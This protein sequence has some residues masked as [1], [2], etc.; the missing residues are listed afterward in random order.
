MGVYLIVVLESAGGLADA[1]MLLVE[2]NALNWRW[3]DSLEQLEGLRDGKSQF[4]Q[5]SCFERMPWDI[6]PLNLTVL[7]TAGQ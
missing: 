6:G 7:L 1:L 3:I 4:Y 5:L 2:L